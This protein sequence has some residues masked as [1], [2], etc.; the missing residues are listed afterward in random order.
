MKSPQLYLASTSPRRRELLAQLGITVEVV[1]Q[2][3]PENRLV[4]ESPESYVKRLA[5]EKARSG[6]DGLGDKSL[7]PVLGADTAVVIENEVLGKPA[8][9]RDFLSMLQRLS[10]R[11]HR[12]LSAVAVVGCDDLGQDREE[13]RISESIVQF[14]AITDKEGEAYWD[15]GEPADKAG[16]YAIQ[17]IAAFFIERIE[18]SYSGVMGLPL[19]ETGELLQRFGIEI[20]D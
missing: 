10:G 17:G 2:D 6:L 9:K 14:R 18:G 15:T 13:L 1:S 7:R 12:V 19:F 4:N 3:V 20:L 5:L 11:S 8:N 16:G